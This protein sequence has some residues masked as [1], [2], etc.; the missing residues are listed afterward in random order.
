MSDNIHKHH[1]CLSTICFG[2]DVGV[3]TIRP[4]PEGFLGGGSVGVLGGGE[5]GGGMGEGGRG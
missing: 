2:K 1:K 3:E 5:G 4:D